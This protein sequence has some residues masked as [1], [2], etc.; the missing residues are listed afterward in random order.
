VTLPFAAQ[1]LGS[2]VADE[3]RAVT[4][5]WWDDDNVPQQGRVT[6]EG[7]TGQR[8]TGAAEVSARVAQQVARDTRTV[9]CG[10]TPWVVQARTEAGS[11]RWR[12]RRVGC[13]G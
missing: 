9:W 8:A 5:T 7:I 2:A 3:G 10:A 13:G 12:A 11:V 6:T 1:A 4:V